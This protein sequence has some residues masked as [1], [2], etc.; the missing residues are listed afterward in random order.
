MRVF[1]DTSAL[2]ALLD[3][4]DQNHPAARRIWEHLRDE[5]ASLITHNYVLVETAD[6]IKSRLGPNAVRALFDR[7]MEVVEVKWI[8]Q[9]IH[10]KALSGLLASETR[11]VGLVDQASFVLMRELDVEKVFAFDQE[12]NHE[13]FE[14]LS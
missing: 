14:V 13:G 9:E 5:G 6:L 3:R 2:Y 7:L 11:P 12:F 4:D 8:H 10:E 1:V